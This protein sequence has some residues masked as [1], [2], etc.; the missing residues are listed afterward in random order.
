LHGKEVELLRESHRKEIEARKEVF[1]HEVL[2]ERE[3]GFWAR[4]APTVKYPFEYF[5]NWIGGSKI[6]A[7]AGPVSV[8]IEPLGVAPNE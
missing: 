7:E 4:W 3:K 1:E 2:R 6:E 8:K 5:M